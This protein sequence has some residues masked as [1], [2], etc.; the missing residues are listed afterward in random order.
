MHR[1]KGKGQDKKYKLSL[2]TKKSILLTKEI[3]INRHTNRTKMFECGA[4]YG[5]IKQGRGVREV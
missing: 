1:S 2:K 5:L 3:M 4:T